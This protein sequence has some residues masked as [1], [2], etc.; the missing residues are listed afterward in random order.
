MMPMPLVAAATA[1]SAVLTMRRERTGTRVVP[2][3]LE[4]GQAREE[5]SPSPSS[6]YRIASNVYVGWA[7]QG[8]RRR[9][10]LDALVGA[11]SCGSSAPMLEV[12]RVK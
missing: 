12:S 9:I 3:E 1:A 4:K 6:D 5:A 8:H 2:S 11:V 7:L 10:Q